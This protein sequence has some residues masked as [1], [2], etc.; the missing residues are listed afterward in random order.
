MLITFSMGQSTKPRHQFFYTIIWL[1][2]GKL[3]ITS[4]VTFFSYR[5]NTKFDIS[6]RT[7]ILCKQMRKHLIT[8]MSIQHRYFVCDVCRVIKCKKTLA[9]ESQSQNYKNIILLHNHIVIVPYTALQVK[10]IINKYNI[11]TDFEH[12]SSCSFHY[13]A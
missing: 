9:A 1:P 2:S 13:A 6:Q 5:C 12:F 4:H 11:K 10:N 3:I 8:D 7:C